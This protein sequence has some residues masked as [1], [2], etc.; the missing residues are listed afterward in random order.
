MLENEIAILKK[1]NHPSII[2]LYHVH[3]TQSHTYLVTEL[4]KG[5][6]LLSYLS[7]KGKLS[8]EVSA[9]IMGDVIEGVKYLLQQGVLHRDIKPANILRSDKSWKI[10]DFGFSVFARE[11]I[12]TKQNVGTPL[13]MPIESLLKNI[14]S[15]ES[16]IF[17][18][19]VMYYELLVGVTPW[20]CRSEKELIK[21]LATLPFSVPEKY[22]LSASIKYLLN[23]MCSV[24]KTT[25]MQREEF[26]NLNLKNFVSLNN[27]NE[28]LYNSQKIEPVR[29]NPMQS[30][31][32]R[33]KR[34]KSKNKVHSKEKVKG[35]YKLN[36]RK[37]SSEKTGSEAR[38]RS[39]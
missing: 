21:K 22:K 3:R 16:D 6:D 14:Y 33:V 7:K 39:L 19:G 18:V 29:K 31:P 26:E 24:D 35:E 2:K 36:K 25:R 4:C 5:G 37:K 38:K 10:A 15:P 8:E 13:Y 17:A 11:E 34:S 28:P 32:P 12:R 1:L 30:P 27:F 9:S 23:K 20:E